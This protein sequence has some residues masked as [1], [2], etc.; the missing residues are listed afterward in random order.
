MKVFIH[1]KFGT[2]NTRGEFVLA[3][4]FDNVDLIKEGETNLTLVFKDEAEFTDIVCRDKKAIDSIQ[5]NP[6]PEERND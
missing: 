1:Y 4:E 5:I 6:N 3:E 2:M